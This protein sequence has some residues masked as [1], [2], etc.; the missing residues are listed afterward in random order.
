VCS[1][2]IS[3]RLWDYIQ[4][5]P[6]FIKKEFDYSK[7]FFKNKVCKLEFSPKHYLV[8]RDKINLWLLESAKTGWSIRLLRALARSHR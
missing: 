5:K 6:E 1:G 8:D 7:V 4:K 3:E 2:L